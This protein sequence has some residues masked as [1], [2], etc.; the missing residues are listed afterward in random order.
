MKLSNGDI[1][2]ARAPLQKLVQ[3]PMPVRAGFL[4]ARLVG[5]LN[6]E[7]VA[8][9]KVRATLIHKYG[10]PNGDGQIAVTP[11]SPQFAQFVADIEEL[12]NQEVLVDFEKPVLPGTLEIEPSALMALEKFVD[13][14][15]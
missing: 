2:N 6:T 15:D 3:L 12:M 9:E 11:A 13:I 1:F 5:K 10:E 4:I 14:G 8:I 7:L